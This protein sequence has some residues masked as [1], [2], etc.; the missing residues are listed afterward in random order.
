MGKAAVRAP[1]EAPVGQ[2]RV[3]YLQATMSTGR[4]GGRGRGRAEQASAARVSH[5]RQYCQFFLPTGVVEQG[6][7]AQAASKAGQLS[8]Q[9]VGTA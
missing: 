6:Q 8:G 2:L 9:R 4:A 3:G 1:A 7:L 5:R